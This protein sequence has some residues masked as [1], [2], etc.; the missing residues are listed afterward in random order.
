MNAIGTRQAFVAH[1]G[2]AADASPE[3]VAAA[4][5]KVDTADEAVIEAAIDRRFFPE[6][7][8]APATE[9][10]SASHE[11]PIDYA[12]AGQLSARTLPGY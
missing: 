12:L 8:T 7:T 6:L 4:I 9:A 1:L 11:A 5:T 10:V 3:D 2:L